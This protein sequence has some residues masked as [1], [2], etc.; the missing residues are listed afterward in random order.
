MHAIQLHSSFSLD[1]KTF[2]TL[3]IAFV[4]I[5]LSYL[6]FHATF[7]RGLKVRL[8]ACNNASDRSSDQ[9]IARFRSHPSEY[10][11]GTH[12][13]Q[14]ICKSFKSAHGIPDFI[15]FMPALRARNPIFWPK[16]GIKNRGF[17]ALLQIICIWRFVRNDLKE[18]VNRLPNLS[19]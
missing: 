19:T 11:L 14:T 3:I 15:S 9:R 4:V 1:L 5:E 16:R 6:L 13:G 18:F 2:T 7:D 12:I 8:F 17:R 10:R